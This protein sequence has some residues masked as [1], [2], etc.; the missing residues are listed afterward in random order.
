[1]RKDYINILVTSNDLGK[2]VDVFITE[3]INSLSRNRI[4]NLIKSE[5][6]MLDNLIIKEQSLKLKNEGIIKVKIPEP[7]QSYIVPIK[8]DLDILFEDKNLLVINKQAGI[9][10]HPGA[11]N[12]NN[13]LVN[14][15]LYHC[16]NCLSDIGGVL[17]P[18]IVH[19]LDKMTSGLM[20]VAK[21]NETHQALSKQFLNRRISRKYICL[22]WKTLPHKNGEINKNIERSKHNRK[23]MVVCNSNRGKIAITN[24]TLIN[25]FFFDTDLSISQY[26]CK[27]LTGRT[28]QIRVHLNYMGC[29]LVG[30]K[31]YKKRIDLSRIPQSIK[32]SI[33]NLTLLE[34]QLLH[35]RSISFYHPI[36]KKEMSFESK[37]PEDYDNF[38]NSLKKIIV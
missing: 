6:V 5:N 27:L 30:D 16:E 34:R 8:M 12:K 4:K 26:E 14:G 33:K 38:V 19:R 24:Y 25:K 10:V 22:V 28:H 21:D 13:T 37:I 32:T 23:K 31:L 1:M 7:T 15:L 17:R 9:V 35:S 18:G 36:L 2:R 3:K 29:P 11:G 20:L